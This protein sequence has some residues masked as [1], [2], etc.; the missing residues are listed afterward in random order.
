MMGG[1]GQPGISRA[2]R[3]NLTN[4]ARRVK[5]IAGPLFWSFLACL[6]HEPVT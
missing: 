3:S 6:S 1:L 5:E 2:V 4:V